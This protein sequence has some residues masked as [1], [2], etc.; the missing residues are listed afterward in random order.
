MRQARVC[1]PGPVTAPPLSSPHRADSGATRHSNHCPS[2]NMGREYSSVPTNL[3]LWSACLATQQ[4]AAQSVPA[5]VPKTLWGVG[6][7]Q[8]KVGGDAILGRYLNK[9]GPGGL[10]Q[11]VKP[12]ADII[13]HSECLCRF[14]C[15]L[16]LSYY[17]VNIENLAEIQKLTYRD[18]SNEMSGSS[19]SVHVQ[20]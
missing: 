3:L 14:V 15:G 7:N 2:A 4:P 20:C 8:T 10:D 17:V 12:P 18:W 19:C 16:V 9:T 11:A 6:A 13:L 1:R 5:P